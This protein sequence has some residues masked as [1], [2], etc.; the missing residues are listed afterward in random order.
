MIDLSQLPEPSAR[1]IAV[2]VKA[3]AERAIRAGHPWVY[4][5]SILKQSHPGTAGDLAVIYDRAKNR[6]LG[7]GLYD[8]LSPI[9]IRIL[10]AKTASTIDRRWFS[11]RLQQAQARRQPLW[12]RGTSGY[13]LAYGESDGLPALVIDRYAAA[14][15]IKLYSSAW[16]PHLKTLI[17]ALQAT[18]PFQ[19]LVLRLS[20]ALQSKPSPALTA[21]GLH[22][23]QRLLGADCR[24]AF[25]ENGLR[26]QA[27]I[28]K[29]HKTGFFFDQR[30]NRQRVRELAAGARVLDVFSYVGAFTVYAL[31]GGAKS[32]TAL[33]SSRAALQG[34]RRSAADNQLN[35]Q[36]VETIAG[37][38]FAA[39]PQ[40]A[41]Q[42]RQFSFV[43][44]DPPTFTSSRADLPRA[45]AA[46]QRLVRLALPL[47]SDGGI[48]MMSS[49]SSRLTAPS[50]FALVDKAIA[51]AGRPREVI[52]QSTHGIDHPIGF[53]PAQY[54]KATF[55]RIH[56]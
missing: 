15:V 21:S 13:R 5:E 53:P 35:P 31:A 10:Q 8:P 9:R 41:A 34:I 26:F 20:R 56:R 7:I 23:G 50:F 18:V 47:L 55:V 32:A 48:L 2:R 22:D 46:Y 39:L 3:A 43:I 25:V 38:A 52:A 1:R 19:T 27:D 44:I 14:L 40:L 12:A 36:R 29:G 30:D 42:Q 11:D 51:Q 6:F 24:A 54:L 17:P 28:C 37:D 49:C 33:D 16:L 4:D 45:A